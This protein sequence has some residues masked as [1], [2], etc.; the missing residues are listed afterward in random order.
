MLLLGWMNYNTSFI[1]IILINIYYYSYCNLFYDLFFMSNIYQ[2]Y[3]YN[4]RYTIDWY[5]NTF[6]L[7]ASGAEGPKCRARDTFDSG[8]GNIIQLLTLIM[9]CILCTIPQCASEILSRVNYGVLFDPIRTAF[10]VHDYWMHTFEV[11][12]HQMI[13]HRMPSVSCSWNDT[14]HPCYY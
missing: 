1:L 12:T 4:Y 7:C 6:F 8:R 11:E 14:N 3:M 5:Y 9:L 13:A 2:F 10:A